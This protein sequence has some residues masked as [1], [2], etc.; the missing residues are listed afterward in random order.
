[1]VK[2]NEESVEVNDLEKVKCRNSGKVFRSLTA[3]I[4]LTTRDSA[5]VTIQ[6]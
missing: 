2:W 5:I 1:M 3:N 6:R 4:S